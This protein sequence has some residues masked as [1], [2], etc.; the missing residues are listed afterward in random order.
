MVN[1]NIMLLTWY[2]MKTYTRNN[3]IET[4][5]DFFNQPFYMVLIMHI[6]YDWEKCTKHQFPLFSFKVLIS[7]NIGYH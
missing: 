2:N 1:E 4:I 5:N 7:R 3:I 6:T